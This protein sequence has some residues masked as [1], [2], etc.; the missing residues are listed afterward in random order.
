MLHAHKNGLHTTSRAV[1]RI[2]PANGGQVR[3][4]SVLEAARHGFVRSCISRCCDGLRRLHKN[5]LWQWA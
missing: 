3:F 2:D 4:Y 5:Y 1:I